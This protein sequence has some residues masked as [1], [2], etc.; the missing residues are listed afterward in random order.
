MAQQGVHIASCL[1]TPCCSQPGG[2]VASK[3][4]AGRFQDAPR[5]KSQLPTAP[6]T[7][8]PVEPPT[9]A[10]HTKFV[11]RLLDFGRGQ[12][13]TIMYNHVISHICTQHA[14][15]VQWAPMGMER[16]KVNTAGTSPTKAPTSK[17]NSAAPHTSPC[18][19][20]TE[21]AHSKTH[22]VPPTQALAQTSQHAHTPR[23]S[24]MGVLAPVAAPAVPIAAA[25]KP[26]P[27]ADTLTYLDMAGHVTHM[28]PNFEVTSHG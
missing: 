23:L 26:A 27:A 10:P 16:P 20:L 9:A 5:C 3:R 21:D 25:P 2:C 11:A 15:S 24:S 8:R 12:K 1:Q 13:H 17:S 6:P 19:A 14:L 7:I 4:L 22:T 18:L 28:S